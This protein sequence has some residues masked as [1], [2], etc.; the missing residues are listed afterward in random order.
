[1][2]VVNREHSPR[3]ALVSTT[4]CTETSLLGKH[5]VVVIQANAVVL[6]EFLVSVLVFISSVVLLTFGAGTR[7]T[8]WVASVV[9]SQWLLYAAGAALF[10]VL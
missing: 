1:M 5:G 3:S 6:A 8:I 4:Y 7:L 10:H 9:F 2:V